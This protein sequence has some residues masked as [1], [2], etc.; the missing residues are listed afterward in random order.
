MQGDE[1]ELALMPRSKPKSGYPV[2]PHRA[3]RPFKLSNAQRDQIRSALKR[4]KPDL[5]VEREFLKSWEGSGQY[6]D[7]D[8]PVPRVPTVAERRLALQQVARTARE[9]T[10]MLQDAG[11]IEFD[12]HDVH[13]G[14]RGGIHHY[15][16]SLPVLEQQCVAVAKGLRPAST[17]KPLFEL[18]DLLADIYLGITGKMPTASNPDAPHGEV[19]PYMALLK[20][21]AGSWGKDYTLGML[22]RPA[23]QAIGKLRAQS[24]SEE[25]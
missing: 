17:R 18:A 21:C 20:A 3:L 16:N 12:W 25:R 7:P 23:R 15:R 4:A 22:Y 1:A 5:D 24:T 2:R 14:L 19:S 6:F 13:K 8:E 9:L 10:A 11:I